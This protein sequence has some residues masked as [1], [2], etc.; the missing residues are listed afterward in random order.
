MVVGVA[1]LIVVAVAVGVGVVVTVGVGGMVGV[2]EAVGVGVFA[3]T[4]VVSETSQLLGF[5]SLSLLISSDQ[6]FAL[7]LRVV[8]AAIANT[9]TTISNSSEAVGSVGALRVASIGALLTRLLQVENHAFRKRIANPHVGG[10][11]RP[12][13]LHG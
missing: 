1:V 12:A 6:Q 13:V 5:P 9:S 2:G 10:S 3:V 7:L 4:R 11:G 8:P